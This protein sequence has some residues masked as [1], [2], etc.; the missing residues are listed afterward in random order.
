[1][2]L[3]IYAEFHGY[4][5]RRLKSKSG[6]SLPYSIPLF[7]SKGWTYNEHFVLKYEEHSGSD[8]ILQVVPEGLHLIRSIE[9]PV[10]V[11]AVCGPLRS[12]KSFFASQLVGVPSAFGVGHELTVCTHGIWMSTHILE[13]DDFAV[14]VLDTEGT[15]A[16]GKD[17]T[18]DNA[19][20]GLLVMI[21]L[22]SSYLIYNSRGVP[23]K[24]KLDEIM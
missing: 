14:V 17:E 5:R 4:R 15:G 23:S 8:D 1:M 9:K 6:G 16:V 3:F 19:M 24:D 22:M 10:A 20:N 12:G 21:T 18:A 11:L 7:L 2:Y 13:C